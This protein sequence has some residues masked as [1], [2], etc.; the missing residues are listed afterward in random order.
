M[1]KK[2]QLVPNNSLITKDPEEGR[3]LAVK[4]VQLAIKQAQRNTELETGKK[5]YTEYEKDS[6]LLVAIVESIV[7]E[8]EIIASANNFW[9]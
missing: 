3:Q 2:N 7:V 9:K 6:R 8:F 1:K 4:M 5:M